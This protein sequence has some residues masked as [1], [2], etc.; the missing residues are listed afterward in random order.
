MRSRAMVARG[1]AWSGCADQLLWGCEVA[2][3]APCD[4]ERLRAT[5]VDGEAMRQQDARKA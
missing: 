5:I 3:T 2:R 4:A 1:A